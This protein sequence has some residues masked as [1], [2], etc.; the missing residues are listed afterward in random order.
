MHSLAN[1]KIIQKKKLIDLLNKEKTSLEKVKKLLDD[2]DYE[3]IEQ[4]I[5]T[6]NNNMFI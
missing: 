4:M 3:V 5:I 1:G 6:F 2:Y